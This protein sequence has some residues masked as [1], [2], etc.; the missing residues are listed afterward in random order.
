MK[1]LCLLILALLIPLTGCRRYPGILPYAREIEDMELIRTLGVDG[2]EGDAV[3]VTAA[4]GD[5][6]AGEVSASRAGSVS[7]AVLA[8]QREGDCYRYFGHVTQL[9]LGEELARRS[10]VPPLEYVLRDVEMRLETALYL[11][12]DG[13]AEQAIRAAAEEG[14]AT[15]RLEALADNAGLTASS[16]PRTV[17]DVL[18]DLDRQ[19]ASFLPAVRPDGA[20]AAAGYGILREGKLVGWAEGDAALGVNLIFGKTDADVVEVEIPGGRAVLRV[21][22]ASA[23][24]RPLW[25]GKRLTGFRVCCRVDANLAEGESAPDEETRAALEEAL[26]RTTEARVTA[27]LEC[28]GALDADFLGLR[29]AAALRAPWRKEVLLGSRSLKGLKMETAVQTEIRRSYHADG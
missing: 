15:D 1:K 7:A 9:L 29:P 12:R 22:G 11:V 21:G 16:M 27:A 24:V 3:H 28:A 8:L 20:L 25:Q 4:G 14:S 2:L 17:K 23:A 26:A 5:G 6:G 10:A 13:T 19:G 18:A